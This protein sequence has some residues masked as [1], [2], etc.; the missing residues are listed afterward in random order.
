M[1]S[2]SDRKIKIIPKYWILDSVYDAV[3][4]Y[5]TVIQRH[6]TTPLIAF[7]PKDGFAP[8]EEFEDALQ[9]VCSGGYKL[10]YLGKD[11]DNIKFRCTH[12]LGHVD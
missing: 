4:L 8:P 9:S 7:N 2:F 11:G 3:W 1:Q 12:T 10:T 5:K 6:K